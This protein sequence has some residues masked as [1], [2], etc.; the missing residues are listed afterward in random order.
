[1]CFSPVEIKTV[2]EEV[3]QELS[4]L[5]EQKQLSLKPNFG[6]NVNTKVVGDRLELHRVFTNL[7]GNAIKFTDTGSIEVRLSN[8]PDPDDPKTSWL[9]I[10]VEDTGSGIALDDQKMIFERFRQGS[11]KRSGSGL[12]LHLSKRI[13]E[14]HQGTLDVQSE[15]GRGSV[16]R[17]CLPTQKPKT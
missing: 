6:E 15:L 1:L 7:I 11:H 10:E 4:P 5:A 8:S 17:V 16:F 2:M 13:V 12:G 3:M 14:T 9:L